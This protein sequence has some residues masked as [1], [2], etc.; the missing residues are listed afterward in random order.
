MDRETCRDS[1]ISDADHRRGPGADDVRAN[2]RATWVRSQRG[3]SSLP[4]SSSNY[5]PIQLIDMTYYMTYSMT[6][7]K[8]NIHEIK[9]QFSKYVGMVEA[10]DTVL[11]C[12]RN[13]PVAEIR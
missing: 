13:V 11:I 4:P 2:S 9:A 7:I 3:C 12:K 5:K 1:N 10:G 8:L 6:M